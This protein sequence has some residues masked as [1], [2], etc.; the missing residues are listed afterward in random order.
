MRLILVLACMMLFALPLPADAGSSHNLSGWAWSSTIGWVSFNNTTGGGANHG[1]NVGSN[2]VMSGYA[3]SPNVGWISFDGVRFDRDTGAVSGTAR[4]LAGQGAS[5]ETGGWGGLIA[6]SGPTYS[7]NAS[8]CE[9]GGYAWGGGETLQNGVIGWLSF[10][11]PGYGVTGTGDACVTVS[12]PDLTPGTAPTVTITLGQPATL[13]GSATNSGAANT[14]TGF[15]NIFVTN[16]NGAGTAWNT[17]VQAAP[18]SGALAPGGSSSFGTTLPGSTFTAPGDYAYAYCADVTLGGGGVWNSTIDEG[19]AGENNNCVGG[20]IRVLAENVPVSPDLVPGT[21][22]LVTIEIGQPAT[23]SGSARNIG[24]GS[25]NAAFNSIFVTNLNGAG[26]AWN[27]VQLASP[28]SGALAPGGSS[29]FET[30]FPGSSFPAAGDY[31]YGYC[32]DF[33]TSWTGSITESSEDNNCVTGVI[34]VIP[35]PTQPP[36]Q[37]SGLTATCSASGTEVTL[38]WNPT[39]GATFYQMRL[40]YHEN[41]NGP[42][43]IDNWLCSTPPDYAE[44]IAATTVTYPVTPGKEYG[45][46]LHAANSA[47]ASAAVGGP[48]FTCSAPAAP[49]A[50]LTASAVSPTTVQEDALTLFTATITNSGTSAAGPSRARF[51]RATSDQGA[52]AALIESGIATPAIAANGGTARVSTN[53]QASSDP[54]FIRACADTDL[55]VPEVDDNNNCGPWTRINLTAV[56]VGPVGTLTCSVSDTSPLV[57]ETVTYTATVSGSATG[58]FSW[59]SPD[60]SG[61]YGSGS[62][63]SRSFPAAQLYAMQVEATGL[64][65]AAQCPQ[66]SV[67]QNWCTTADTDLSIT[68]SPMRVRADEFSTIT[69]SATGVNGQG[70]ECTVTGPGVSAAW[71]NGIPVSLIPMCSAS[72]SDSI[73]I[74]TQSTFTLTCGSQSESVTVNVIPRFQ[75]F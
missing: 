25:T 5:T 38:A 56:P 8:G 55:Q 28:A 27:T 47:G 67:E 45:W 44:D 65:G 33:N 14:G 63:V 42:G 43:C 29:S 15:N 71:R 75:E 61:P 6:L 21:A 37:P 60:G 59:S 9:W 23:V 72:G 34:R 13:A 16:L 51:Q 19:A 24:T 64:P 11:G 46:W 74:R 18:A 3:W 40:N 69:W 12:K 10:R 30:T 7:V 39:A 2:G 1:V 70:A 73:Q 57:G 66:V 68:A 49:L 48:I 20:T 31:A 36:T 50:E 58:P 22:P 32:N 52:N 53:F 41:D 4:A 54:L 26:T 17:V 62:S 35:P